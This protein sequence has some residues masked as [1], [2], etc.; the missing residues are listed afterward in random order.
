M[1]AIRITL[2]KSVW[3]KIMAKKP[4]KAVKKAV[5]SKGAASKGGNF[6]LKFAPK[7]PC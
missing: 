6:N 5:G 3:R 2:P 1:L 7:K 4:M